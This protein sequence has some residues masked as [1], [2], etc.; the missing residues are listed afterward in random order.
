MLRARILVLSDAVS[1]GDR[2]DQSGPAVRD[3]LKVAG[4]TVLEVNV[5]PDDLGL[6]Q[7][8]LEALADGGDCDGIFTSGGTG[9]GPR[10]VT[11]EATRAVIEKDVPG[12]AELMRAEGIKK[13]R[14]AV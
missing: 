7:K 6:I 12:V 5:L 2:E 13:T 3:T 9:I 1:R 10:D 4:W 11:P 14:R 8:T